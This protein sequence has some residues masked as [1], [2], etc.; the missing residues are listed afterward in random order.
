MQVRAHIGITG[1]VHIDADSKLNPAYTVNICKCDL[2]GE[3]YD[4][5]LRNGM[6]E[7]VDD[8]QEM[9]DEIRRLLKK[10]GDGYVWICN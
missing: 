2:P 7:F 1:S 4:V 6:Y 9:V 8:P 5:I 10:E 3:S